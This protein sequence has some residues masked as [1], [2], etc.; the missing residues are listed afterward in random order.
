MS[1][2]TIIATAVAALAATTAPASAMAEDVTYATQV[3][4]SNPTDGSQEVVT[5]DVP[6]DW[7]RDR[8][9]PYSVGFFDDVAPV[10][11]IVIDLNPRANTV[12]ETKAEARTLRAL[13]RNYYR[14]LD[15]RVLDPGKKIRVRWVFAYRDAQTDDTWSYTS[16]LLM[17]GERLV[18]DGRY[19]QREELSQIRRHVVTSVQFGA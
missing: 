15:F 3:V 17:H 7:V 10:R 18:I 2:I 19:S 11:S 1:R 5:L 9:N 13:G 8:L 14:E 16:V 6:A 12:R 4:R